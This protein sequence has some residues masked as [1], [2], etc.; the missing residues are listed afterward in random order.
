MPAVFQ[1]RAAYQDGGSGVVLL[2]RRH[3]LRQD[4]RGHHHDLEAELAAV[5]VGAALGEQWRRWAGRVHQCG[6]LLPLLPLLL[7]LLRLRPLLLLLL[8]MLRL[9]Q[10]LLQDASQTHV[11]PAKMHASTLELYGYGCC[12]STVLQWSGLDDG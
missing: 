12:P 8:S 3:R 6:L 1:V 4:Y 11:I 2:G 7:R 10:P 5:A 9:H